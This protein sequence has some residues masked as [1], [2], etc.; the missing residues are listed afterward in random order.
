M[1]V[2]SAKGFT[3]SGVKAGIKDSGALDLALVVNDGPE[4]TAAAVTPRLFTS[5]ARW[6]RRAARRPSC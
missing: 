6:P 4:V 1:S 2:T 5:R 3:A